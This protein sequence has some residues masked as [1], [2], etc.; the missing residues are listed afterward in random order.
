MKSGII[1]LAACLFSQV[2]FILCVSGRFL[3]VFVCFAGF[4]V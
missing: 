2:E 3:L 1:H 4:L